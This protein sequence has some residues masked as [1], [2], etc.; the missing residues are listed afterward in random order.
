M[1]VYMSEVLN[2]AERQSD[3]NN[4]EEKFVMRHW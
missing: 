4:F 3:V 1:I 2:E